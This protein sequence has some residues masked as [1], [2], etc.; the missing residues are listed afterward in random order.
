MQESRTNIGLVVIIVFIDGFIKPSA[1]GSLR[2]PAQT[3]MFPANWLTLPLSFG[4][5]MCMLFLVARLTALTHHSAMGS[6]LR[7]P[8]NL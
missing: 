8:D 6:S 5:L 3:Y 1:P 2:D 7:L 4:L